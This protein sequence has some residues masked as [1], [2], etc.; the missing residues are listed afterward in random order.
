MCACVA[1]MCV[2]VSSIILV[3]STLFIFDITVIA[4]IIIAM[5]IN[6]II[7]SGKG[8]HG[9]S[10]NETILHFGLHAGRLW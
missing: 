1:Y 10:V 3:H 8:F 9:R 2:S 4:I 5:I 7:Y 6:V